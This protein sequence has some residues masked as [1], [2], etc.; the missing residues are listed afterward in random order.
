MSIRESVPGP[1]RAI[2][3]VRQT[4]TRYPSIAAIPPLGG[5]FSHGCFPPKVDLQPFVAIVC[6]CAPTS[7]FT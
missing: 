1:V 4:I 3:A 7:C 2:H 5:H 6:T